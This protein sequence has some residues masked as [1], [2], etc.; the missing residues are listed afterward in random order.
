MT[1][2]LAISSNWSS[3]VFFFCTTRA[4]G[5]YSNPK[6]FLIRFPIGPNNN[7]IFLR[8]CNTRMFHSNGDAII[9]VI[10]LKVLF[11]YSTHFMAIEQWEL[12]SGPHLLWHGTAIYNFYF[13]FKYNNLYTFYVYTYLYLHSTANRIQLVVCNIISPYVIRY[14]MSLFDMTFK[15]RIWRPLESIEFL[16]HTISRIRFSWFLQTAAWIRI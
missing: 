10:G 9:T 1:E 16:F 11:K 6:Y 4:L 13:Y 14:Y 5:T 3:L 12:V 15:S 2:D 7:L 8:S